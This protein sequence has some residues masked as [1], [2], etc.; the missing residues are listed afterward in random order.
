MN[1]QTTEQDIME[2]IRERH[3]VRQYLDTPIE[4]GKRRL[5]SEKAAMLNEQYGL[6]IQICFDEPECFATGIARYSKFEGCANYIAMIGPKRPELEE[7]VGYA[8]EQLVLYAQSLGLNTCWVALTHGKTKAVAECGEKQ[9]I[10]IALGYGKTQGAWRKSKPES[11]LS[12]VSGVAPEWFHR[13]MEAAMLAPTSMNQQKFCFV[14]T[15]DAV[16]LKAGR[17]I[18]AKIDAGIVRYHFEAA[19]GHPVE[20]A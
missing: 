8:G 15:G 11:Q 14:L 18:N 19:S 6:H 3:S 16:T 9:V 2:L 4:E 12:Q 10:V 7:T 13:G 1:G 5:L 17:A 20:Q